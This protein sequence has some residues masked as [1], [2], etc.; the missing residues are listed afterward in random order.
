[1]KKQSKV[2]HYSCAPKLQSF[3]PMPACRCILAIAGKGRR[4]D[5]GK[6]SVMVRRRYQQGHLF[7]RG[8]RWV[9]R[10]REMLI[11]PDGSTLTV[12]RSVVVADVR[13]VPTRGEARRILD[14]RLKQLS[15][16]LPR[17]QA[18]CT[19]SDFAVKWQDAVLPTYRAST[20]QFYAGILRRHLIPY[21]GG[22]R[23]ADIRTPDVQTYVNQ[24][25]NHYAPSVLRHI[26]ATLSQVLG[27]AREW[28]YVDTNSALGVRLPPKGTVQPKVTYKPEEVRRLLLRM[29]ERYRTM[30]VLAAVTGIRASELFALRWADVDLDR[31]IIQIRRSFYRGEFGP[32]KSKASERAIPMGPSLQVLLAVHRQHAMTDPEALVFPNA[33]GKPYEANNIIQ[34]VLHPAM[35]SLGLPET[36]WRAFRRSVATALSELR[37][38]VK[39][40][41]KVLGHSSPETTLGIYTQS[42]EE[43]QRAA[44]AKLETLMFPNVPTLA[45]LPGGGSKLVN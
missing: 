12:Q 18:V 32:P 44:M 23:L 31:Q 37:E 13:E 25:S 27:S 6:D 41:Q 30:V 28:G 7:K 29:P 45:Q 42:V 3:K 11:Q 15:P 2:E 34:R 40:A 22:W 26:R 20:R 21:F 33:A 24:M 8:R 10:F 9:A 16:G 38:P 19:F 5:N 14:N 35:R 43:S 36:G 17:V 39:T 1:M 4:T